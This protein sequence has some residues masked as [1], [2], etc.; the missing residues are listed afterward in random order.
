METSYYFQLEGDIARH[1]AADDDNFSQPKIFW[2]KVL[3]DDQRERL[4][5]NVAGHLSKAQLSL[6]TRAIDMFRNVHEDLANG[7]EEKLKKERNK[8]TPKVNHL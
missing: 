2:E 5:E 3:T 6:Q 4:I 7:L 1:D 8:E